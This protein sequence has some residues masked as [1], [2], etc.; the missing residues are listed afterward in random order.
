MECG[1]TGDQIRSVEHASKNMN[2]WF[3]VV[4]CTANNSVLGKDKFWDMVMLQYKLIPKDLP[5]YYNGCEKNG[6]QH[7]LQF[8]KVGS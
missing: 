5:Q 2:H 7:V 3:T 6:L 8:K 1:Y 4:P